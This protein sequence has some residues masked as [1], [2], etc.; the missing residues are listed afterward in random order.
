MVERFVRTLWDRTITPR[1]ARFRMGFRYPGDGRGHSGL[2]DRAHLIALGGHR[3]ACHLD[4]GPT[5]FQHDGFHSVSVSTRLSSLHRYS[6]MPRNGP[7]RTCPAR[8]P[9]LCSAGHC[10]FAGK[11]GVDPDS[12]LGKWITTFLTGRFRRSA[13][14]STP[15][16]AGP[17]VAGSPRMSMG[18]PVNTSAR[19][20]LLQSFARRIPLARFARIRWKDLPIARIARAA[21]G[22]FRRL[23][24]HAAT[25]G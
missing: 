24:P 5:T 12:C 13:A 23:R 18:R 9:D 21:H 16:I 22:I 7:D 4:S 1:V 2:D 20:A 8:Q 14:C 11:E 10:I 19:Y 6:T 17:A 15:L 3:V 25:R